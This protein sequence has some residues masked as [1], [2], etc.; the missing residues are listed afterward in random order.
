MINTAKAAMYSATYHRVLVELVEWSCFVQRY[1]VYHLR[2]TE[3]IEIWVVSSRQSRCKNWHMTKRPLSRNGTCLPTTPGN[4][5]RSVPRPSLEAN[6]RRDT[7]HY[8][9]HHQTTPPAPENPSLREDLEP[10]GFGFRARGSRLIGNSNFF[11][12]YDFTIPPPCEVC[13]MNTLTFSFNETLRDRPGEVASWAGSRV[14]W[15][16]FGIDCAMNAGFQ[17]RAGIWWVVCLFR[18][19]SCVKNVCVCV[20]VQALPDTRRNCSLLAIS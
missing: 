9:G 13:V 14:W 16:N 5:N 6:S 8:R 17:L 19:K 20:C 18:N 4:R 1:C 11:L 7:I 15:S 12:I 10:I 3:L 2:H